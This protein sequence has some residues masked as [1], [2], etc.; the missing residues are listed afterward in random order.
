MTEVRPVHG[1]PL[2]AA[3]ALAFAGAALVM[4]VGRE[5]LA[6]APL[7]AVA[8]VAAVAAATLL[9][10]AALG[11]RL[12]RPLFSSH[13]P[14]SLTA[15]AMGAMAVCLPTALLA[16][17]LTTFLAGGL[18]GLGLA[19]GLT[20][21]VV[22]AGLAVAQAAG[23]EAGVSPGRL[24]RAVA[25][26]TVA[27]ALFVPLI[28][29]PKLSPLNACL[30]VG[31][32]CAAVG[33]ICASA[34]PHGKRSLETWLSVLALVFVLLLPLSSLIDARS[35]AWCDPAAAPVAAKPAP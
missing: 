32:G 15:P 11:A 4:L 21:L 26:G 31:I 1:R 29:V 30:D 25:G 14:A 5:A 24:L 17:R 13:H 19:A 2:A 12:V 6:A 34:A 18:A 9:I 8:A 23:R 3:A 7:A 35:S 28:A 10:L 33:I 22:G 16:E 20:G 27:G